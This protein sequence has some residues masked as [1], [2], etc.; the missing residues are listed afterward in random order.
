VAFYRLRS[1]DEDG[2][3][4]ISAEE[5]MHFAKNFAAQQVKLAEERARAEEAEVETRAARR[6][7]AWLLAA[8]LLLA[9]LL[10]G[11]TAATLA[12]DRRP[13]RMGRGVVVHLDIASFRFDAICVWYRP[14]QRESSRNITSLRRA[15]A[16]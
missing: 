14:E 4:E 13:T 5:V 15:A 1:L 2:D 12:F 7:A 9:A 10:A 3:G 11:S 6:R 16:T 8:V